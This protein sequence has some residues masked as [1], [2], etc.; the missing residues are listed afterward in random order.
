MT[1]QMPECFNWRL[2]SNSI[3]S[4]DACQQL[5]KLSFG[6]VIVYQMGGCVCIIFI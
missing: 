1:S 4:F 6:L 2:L 3:M 5:Y